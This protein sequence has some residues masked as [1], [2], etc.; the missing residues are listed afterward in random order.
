MVL[1]HWQQ[2]LHT[3]SQH[4]GVRRRA[5]RPGAEAGA[6][7]EG[8]GARRRWRWVTWASEPAVRTVEALL[9]TSRSVGRQSG[10]WVRG[11]E[12]ERRPPRSANA[13]ESTWLAAM[14][15]G[16]TCPFSSQSESAA[17]TLRPRDVRPKMIAHTG[18]CVTGEKKR[19]S[20]TKGTAAARQG[21][22]QSESRRCRTIG[23][24]PV[25]ALFTSSRLCSRDVRTEQHASF[26]HRLVDLRVDLEMAA[27]D[28]LGESTE[29]FNLA[30][31][32]ARR[33]D[34]ALHAAQRPRARLT[35]APEEFDE[36]NAAA[37]S[38]AQWKAVSVQGIA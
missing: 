36:E 13:W 25:S 7:A 31:Q 10:C 19:V 26:S 5:G 34:H 2:R 30:P 9:V 22:T 20:G 16:V 11:C 1:Q 15:S 35:I 8:M 24:E 17:S 23:A 18:V 12:G 14:R 21:G 28:L 4:G 6:G 37:R 32:H 27:C 38:W 33:E 3:L 29:R